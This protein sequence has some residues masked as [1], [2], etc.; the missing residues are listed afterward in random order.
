VAH[1]PH[2]LVAFLPRLPPLPLHFLPS[3]SRDL[4]VRERSLVDHQDQ[5]R[6]LRVQKYVEGPALVPAF[7]A[8]GLDE[9]GCV[10]ETEQ[11]AAWAAW[12][13]WQQPHQMVCVVVVIVVIVAT[14]DPML[15]AL[16]PRNLVYLVKRA[17][18]S[19]SFYE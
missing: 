19:E 9:F 2:C 14:S 4:W 8:V 3:A 1:H 6:C 10:E 7:E 18:Q 16:L 11:V 13:R 15:P 12:E 5:L 17:G